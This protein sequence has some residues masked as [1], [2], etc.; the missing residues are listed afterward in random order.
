MVFAPAAIVYHLHPSGLW[1]YACRKAQIGRWKVRVHLQHPAKAASDSYTPW[2]QKA[3]IALLP[4]VGGLTITAIL[5]LVPWAVI[6]FMALL[7]LISTLPLVFKAARQGW[8]VALAAPVLAF[9]RAGAL[10]LGIGWGIADLAHL[11]KNG[12]S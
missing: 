1:A 5:G 7:G 11:L 9:V 12:P 3:Q 2:T 6:L 10:V 8:S 4:I